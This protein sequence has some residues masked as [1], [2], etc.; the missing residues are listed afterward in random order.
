M[1]QRL[2]KRQLIEG[3]RAQL[4][5]QLAGGVVN[6][7]GEIVNLAGGGLSLRRIARPLY[8]LR[9]DLNGGNILADFIVQLA[10]QAFAR[11]LFGMDQLFG[12]RPPRRQLRFQPLAIVVQVLREVLLAADGNPQPDAEQRLGGQKNL[13]LHQIAESNANLAGDGDHHATQQA[14]ED[15]ALPAELPR[16]HHV[17]QKYHN[18]QQALDF[19]RQHHLGADTDDK[20]QAAPDD[21]RGAQRRIVGIQPQQ[22]V[23]VLLAQ[24]FKDQIDKRR[25]QHAAGK[26]GQAE[27]HRRAFHK[28]RQQGGVE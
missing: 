22:V 12:Q 25:Q 16:H 3:R 24:E 26:R 27:H 8:Q 2:F 11:I 18:Q 13:Q 9:L 14:G 5:Q 7:S 20:E 15:A 28:R 6:A 1:V 23:A 4:A 19:R 17:R 10:R 21:Q